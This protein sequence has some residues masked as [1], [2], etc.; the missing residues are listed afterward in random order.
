MIVVDTNI[1]AYMTFATD[2]SPTVNSLHQHDPEWET[3]TLWRS[4]FLNILALYYRKKLIDY[5]ESL[6]ALDFAERLIGLREHRLSSQD[7]LD[8]VTHSTCSSYDC[9]FVGLA[10]KLETKLITY[11]KKILREFSS[12]AVT[13]EDYLDQ[14]K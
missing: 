14:L 13:P 7:I 2:Y 5:E 12:L 1:I 8:L 4:E 10:K 6:K 11:D 9:E 3:P